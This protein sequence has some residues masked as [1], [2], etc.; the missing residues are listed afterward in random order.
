LHRI[1]QII[2]STINKLAGVRMHTDRCDIRPVEKSDCANIKS[3]D[4]GEAMHVDFVTF[5]TIE[6]QDLESDAS[7]RQSDVFQRAETDVLDLTSDRHDRVVA[8][9][10]HCLTKKPWRVFLWACLHPCC[11]EILPCY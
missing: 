10:V 4:W 8:E 1:Q 11:C 2:V 5:A 7:R 6:I 3:A 9:L